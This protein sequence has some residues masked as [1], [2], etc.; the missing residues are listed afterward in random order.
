[1]LHVFPQITKLRAKPGV[2]GQT[3]QSPSWLQV[4]VPLHTAASPAQQPP[5]QSVLQAR[6]MLH[7]QQVRMACET[8]V[9][10]PIYHASN[11]VG[12]QDAKQ[13]CSVAACD[14]AAR[15][16]CHRSQIVGRVGWYASLTDAANISHKIYSEK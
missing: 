9:L 14:R 11:G 13:E 3:E 15:D 1:M 5:M 6:V 12:F 16:H 4:D 7:T 8:D 10:P 2:Q